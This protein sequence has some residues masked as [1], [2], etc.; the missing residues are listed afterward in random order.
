MIRFLPDA[1]TGERVVLQL[2]DL[3][4]RLFLGVLNEAINGVRLDDLADLQQQLVVLNSLL[5]R[6]QGTDVA[7]DR[8][9]LAAF[10]S[11]CRAVLEE[12]GPEE[13]PTRVGVN[14]RDA[15][16]ILADVQL[17]VG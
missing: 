8:A 12:L 16:N 13:F 15:N 14:W 5:E 1:F 2:D 9:A 3:G 11:A 10:A 4:Y 6:N 7:V 17:E